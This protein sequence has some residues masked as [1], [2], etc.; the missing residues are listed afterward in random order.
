MGRWVTTTTAFKSFLSDRI[1]YKSGLALTTTEM[2]ELLADNDPL[3]LILKEQ[4]EELVRIRTD[5]IED[6][7]QIMLHRLG[8]TNKD[9]VG[10]AP[11]ILDI[12]LMHPPGKRVLFKEVLALLGKTYFD[13]DK[14]SIFDNFN[15]DEYY[16]TIQ[17][18]LGIEA[19]EIAHRL[20]AL[21]K[22]SEEASPWDWL[23]A[24]TTEWKSPI[25]LKNL[26]ESESL[27]AMYGT[28]LDQRYINYLASNTEKLS[29]IHWR[30]F[31]AL[32]AEYFERSGYKVQIGPG[33]NDGG[34]D[35]RVWNEAS[36]LSQPPIQ[37]IQCKRTKSKIDK[38]LVK[39]LWA[40]VTDEKAKGGI[41]VTTSSFSPGARDICKVRNYPIREANRKT[42]IQWL[43]ELRNTDRGVF[44]GE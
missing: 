28:F 40:D 38:V 8:V 37:L 34:I 4:S 7:F 5:H 20:V 14:H 22:E 24:R 19:L 11:T 3:A 33:R 32:T 17:S 10:H 42:V 36:S 44:M 12:E 39:S 6:T 30:K 31:E 25:E 2:V 15:E 9:F 16:K 21:T 43:T 27:S 1:G 29:E 41:I 13:Q 23:L 35:I 18:T 26:F